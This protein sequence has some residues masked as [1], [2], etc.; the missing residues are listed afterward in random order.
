MSRLSWRQRLIAVALGA[1]FAAAQADS[2]EPAQAV[3][4]AMNKLTCSIHVAES[5]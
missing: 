4:A 5:C 3:H 2:G 1:L